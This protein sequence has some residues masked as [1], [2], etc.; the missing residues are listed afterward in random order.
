MGSGTSGPAAY[1]DSASLLLGG[2]TTDASATGAY[3][4]YALRYYTINNGVY[5]RWA[6][7]WID[8]TQ[9]YLTA[10]VFPSGAWRLMAHEIGH[11][12][13][14]SHPGAYNAGPG[15]QIT[16]ATHAEYIEDSSQYT[17]MSYFNETNTGANFGRQRPLTPM[18]HDIAA[19]QRLYGADYS[20]RAGDT[21]YGFNSNTGDQIFTFFSAASERVFCI[22]DG[23]GEDTI[24]ASGYA[25]ASLIDLN[26]GAFSN[27]GPLTLSGGVAT[28]Q[29]MVGNIS[30][31]Y[32]AVIENAIGGSG[33]DTLTGNR[34]NNDLTGNGG[35]NA[36][37]GGAGVDRAMY[38]SIS[39]FATIT[40][41]G[42]GTATISGAGFSDTLTGVEVAHFL[43]RDV[44][45]RETT[46][47]DL[48]ASGT[49]DMV[50]QSGGTV[51]A[52]MVANGFAQSGTLI[53]GGVDGWTVQGTGDFNGDGTTDVI[54][55]NGGTVVQW[56]MSNGA[57]A[58]GTLVGAGIDGWTVKGTGD[59]NSD[60]TTDVVLQNGGTVVAWTMQNG[61]A[62]SGV[63]VGGGVDGW[64]VVGTGDFNGDG[65]SDILLQNGGTL[66]AW[67]M[68]NGA[69]IGGSVLSSGIDGWQVVGT[70]DFNGDGTTDVVVKNGG[71]IVDLLVQNSVATTGN[72]IGLGLEA[73]DVVATGDYNGD[74]T[75]DIALT[76]GGIVVDWS[77][78][79][80]LVTAGNV[81]GGNG[82]FSVVA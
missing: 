73:W 37:A 44:A 6:N 61:V 26:E 22:W 28:G 80:G 4:G 64:D 31:A 11:A 51:V 77:M 43:D 18:M 59:F 8:N 67:N 47:S 42:N 52:W 3:D 9:S 68:R 10:P 5:N 57:N 55:Q 39:T 63:V 72:V 21:V 82:T 29:A 33:S 30:I 7:V 41:T 40:R 2:F 56:S 62:A 70:G 76:S 53:G 65:A 23:A 75:A 16:Y 50:L 66:V 1:T 35:S 14:L 24:D 49:S 19:I 71:T 46:R 45:I 13:G 38:N 15:V 36:I 60:G 54:L 27:I 58:G 69:N 78:Q 74:G 20:T 17:I 81:L 48:N 25:L 34:A 79:N 32:G 12:I